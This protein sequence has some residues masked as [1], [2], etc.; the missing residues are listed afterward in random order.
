LFTYKD[1][2]ALSEWSE[3]YPVP[4]LFYQASEYQRRTREQIRYFLGVRTVPEIS[5]R[6][7]PKVVEKGLTEKG[8]KLT[9]KSKDQTTDV[10][11]NQPEMTI[12]IC[13]RFQALCRI[14]RARR[15][16]TS[17]RPFSVSNFIIL[18]VTR[19]KS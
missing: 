11:P 16:I 2:S 7:E 1:D 9:D 8:K 3:F 19:H 13:F 14:L 12:L 17:R 6:P 4:R 5:E 18:M 15:L 10:D